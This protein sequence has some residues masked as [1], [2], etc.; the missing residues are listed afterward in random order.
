MRAPFRLHASFQRANDAGNIGIEAVE[1]AVSAGAQ[2]VAGAD[3]AGERV[4]VGEVR[5]DFLL[6]G[7]GDGDTVERQVADDGEQV[8]EG[9]YLER[10]HDGVDVFAAEGRGVHERRKGV[11]DGI[12][13]D[14]KMRVAWSSCSRR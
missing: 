10:E 13:G 14:P 7:H 11:G 3:T 4:H 2:G 5:Q 6:E 1:L 9:L 12:A 8:V